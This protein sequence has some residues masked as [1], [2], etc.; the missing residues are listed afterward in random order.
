M[1]GAD[2]SALLNAAYMACVRRRLLQDGA[3]TKKEMYG[4]VC[5]INNKQTNFD[6]NLNPYP[7][8]ILTLILTIAFT[9]TLEKRHH[10][11]YPAAAS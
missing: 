11:W 5:A 8:L 2:L 4:V 9:L 10:H 7:H 6:P 3:F 1:T